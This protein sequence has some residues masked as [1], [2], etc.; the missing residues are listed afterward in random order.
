MCA[1]KLTTKLHKHWKRSVN[2]TQQIRGF[3]EQTLWIVSQLKGTAKEAVHILEL[4]DFGR[5]RVF[6]WCGKSWTNPGEK[7]H[8]VYIESSGVF[9]RNVF[10]W[11][12]KRPEIFMD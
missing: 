9:E 4:G 7:L 1:W 8:Q 2:I 6:G 3:A 5:P 12:G 11:S 10:G